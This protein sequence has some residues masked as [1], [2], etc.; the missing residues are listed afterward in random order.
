MTSDETKDLGPAL[1][2]DPTR[3]EVAGLPLASE[4]I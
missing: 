4:C 1:P 3:D 2:A